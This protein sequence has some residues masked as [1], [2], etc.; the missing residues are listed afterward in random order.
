MYP[1]ILLKSLKTMADGT[2]KVR[3][4]HFV[5][6]GTGRTHQLRIHMS[7]LGHPI[8]GDQLYGKEGFILRGRGLFL[9]AVELNF[10]HPISDW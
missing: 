6:D 5:A 9:C 7:E 8:L 10:P 2:K 1:Q 4:T 3:Q